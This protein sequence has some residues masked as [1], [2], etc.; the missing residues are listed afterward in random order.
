MN[1]D[2]NIFNSPYT[3]GGTILTAYALPLKLLLLLRTRQR[4]VNALVGSS[5]FIY[6]INTLARKHAK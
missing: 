2:R 1:R 4:V 6:V 5:R 3:T